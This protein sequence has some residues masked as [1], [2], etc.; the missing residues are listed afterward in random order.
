MLSNVTH[1]NV[2]KKWKENPDFLSCSDTLQLEGTCSFYPTF[3]L[4]TGKRDSS[5][6]FVSILPSTRRHAPEELTSFKT[7]Q[8]F[9]K[10][11]SFLTF[12]FSFWYF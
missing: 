5:E 12:M 8:I 6:S 10:F 2:L 3:N 11:Y 9:T 4:N 1:S 7:L